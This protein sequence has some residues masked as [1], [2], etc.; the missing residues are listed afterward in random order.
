MKIFSKEEVSSESLCYL[1]KSN[2]FI[3]F[4]IDLAAP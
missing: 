1:M 4:F 3:K 2:F